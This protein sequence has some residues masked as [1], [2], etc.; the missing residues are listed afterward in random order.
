MRVKCET[1]ARVLEDVHGIVEFSL[2]RS[3]NP[4][5][6]TVETHG[7]E[8]AYFLAETDP[9]MALCEDVEESVTPARKSEAQVF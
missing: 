5:V 9:Y 3:P 2:C 6:E 7:V 8:D 4:Q 1:Q